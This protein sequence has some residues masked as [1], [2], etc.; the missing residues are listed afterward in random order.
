MIKAE[1]I[2][3]LRKQLDLSMVEFGRLFGKSSVAVHYWE[4]G[5]RY[6]RREV[7]EK[8]EE[9]KEKCIV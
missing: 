5:I 2:K 6:P 1:E 8:L 3:A 7:Q 9:L 4:K